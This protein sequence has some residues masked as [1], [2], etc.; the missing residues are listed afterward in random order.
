MGVI[1]FVFFNCL[2]VCFLFVKYPLG[3]Y[4]HIFCFTFFQTTKQKG[5]LKKSCQKILSK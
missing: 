3:I 2:F 4:L 1:T 5:N